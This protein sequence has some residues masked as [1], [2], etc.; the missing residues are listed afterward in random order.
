[1]NGSLIGLWIFAGM[2]YQGHQLPPPNP[3]LIMSYDF[4]PDGQNKLSYH[5]LNEKGSCQRTAN[6]L[7]DEVSKTLYQK[8]VQVDP[9]NASWCSDDLDM[10]DGTETWNKAWVENET[11][12]LMLNLGEESLTYLWKKKDP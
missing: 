12:H 9:N 1:M 2:I 5:R 3:N 7:H 6:Y 10:R 8:V 4:L 11:L